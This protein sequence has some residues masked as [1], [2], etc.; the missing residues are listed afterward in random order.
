MRSGNKIF[1]GVSKKLVIGKIR[2]KPNIPFSFIM[3]N[4]S[5][6]SCLKLDFLP[7][8]ASDFCKWTSGI[9]ITINGINAIKKVIRSIQRSVAMSKNDNSKAPSGAPTTPTT[10]PE[11]NLYY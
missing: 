6:K 9:L 10:I 3:E 7:L 8:E 1:R 11:K 2:K 4:P 5:L